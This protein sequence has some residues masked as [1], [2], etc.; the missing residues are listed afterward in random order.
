MKRLTLA[1]LL[2]MTVTT[3]SGCGPLYQFTNWVFYGKKYD[4]CGPPLCPLAK[5]FSCCDAGCPYEP[6]GYY[7]PCGSWGCGDVYWGDFPDTPC[8]PCDHCGN[9]VGPHGDYAYGGPGYYE[10]WGQTGPPG[11]RYLERTQPRREGAQPPGELIRPRLDD[12]PGEE[13]PM[14]DAST[15]RRPVRHRS[16]GRY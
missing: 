6:C 15:T 16:R 10:G 3:S 5:C 8:Q 11:S 2:A 9:Y 4:P 1:A 7:G 13:M 12:E 14:P